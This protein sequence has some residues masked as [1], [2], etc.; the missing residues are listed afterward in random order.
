MPA[1]Q[2]TT[3]PQPFT[4]YRE[5]APSYWHLGSLWTVMASAST[6]GNALTVMDQ[7]MPQGSGPPLHV[8]ERWHE[9]FYLLEGEIRF[10]VHDEVQTAT[11]G[12]LLSIPPITPH[13]FVVVSTTARVLNLYTPGGFDEQISLQ[14]VSAT[15]LTLPPAGSQSQ[16]TQDQQDAFTARAVA[17]ASQQLVDGIEDLLADQR[18]PMA[19]H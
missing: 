17:L 13:G 6:T 19:P 4:M 16:P 11:A 14:A 15:A 9:Y 8:H 2:T 10:Q 7:L 1:T 12:A 5:D 3:A 18:A